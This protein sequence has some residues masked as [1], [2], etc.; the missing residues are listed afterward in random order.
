M[1]CLLC[2]SHPNQDLENC[3]D[4]FSQ[5]QSIYDCLDC[6]QVIVVVPSQNKKSLAFVVTAVTYEY[7]D[8]QLQQHAYAF[9][10]ELRSPPKEHTK[11]KIL[12]HMD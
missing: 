2:E 12:G 8:L 9:G 3:C 5:N 10:T 1:E 4:W 7:C 6:D 11:M